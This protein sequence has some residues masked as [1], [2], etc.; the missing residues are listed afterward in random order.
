MYAIGYLVV[1]YA[2]KLIIAGLGVQ[3]ILPFHRQYTHVGRLMVVLT[4]M[5]GGWFW[6]ISLLLI[7]LWFTYGSRVY[8]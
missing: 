7:V 2:F 1:Q 8:R 6:Y 3:T 5:R 4:L